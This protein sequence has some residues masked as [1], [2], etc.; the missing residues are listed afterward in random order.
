VTA[1]GPNLEDR[2]EERF[3][4]CAY[5]LIID[6]TTWDF[7]AIANP[8]LTLGGNMGIQ[9]AQLL[10]QKGVQVILTGNCGQNA[11][12]VFGSSN[13]QVFSGITGSVRQAVEAYCSGTISQPATQPSAGPQPGMG[14]GMRSGMGRCMGGAGRGM[15][16][17][18]GQGMGRGKGCRRQPGLGGPNVAQGMPYFP[19]NAWPHQAPMEQ[20]TLPVQNWNQWNLHNRKQAGAPLVATVDSTR[21]DGCG[22]C[23]INC[24]TGA[25]SVD[26]TAV[27]SAS[28]CDGCGQCV[29]VCPQDALALRKAQ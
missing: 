19:G 25:I 7:E 23:Q 28:L 4:R 1:T 6:P 10:A 15:G 3:G 20:P 17:G 5:F 11:I 12:Q 9:S 24:P 16:R 14:Q 2:V 13:I 29:S 22:Q 27:I 21:C 18:M 8:N 26:T